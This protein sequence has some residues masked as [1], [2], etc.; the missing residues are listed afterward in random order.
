VHLSRLGV[1]IRLRTTVQR[2]SP[3]WVWLSTGEQLA[4]NTVVWCAGVAPSPLVSR[5]QLPAACLD[6]KGYI[7][8]DRDLRV[9][10]FENVWAIGD[11]A[12]NIDAHGRPYPATAQ[13]AIKEAKVLAANLARVI[14]GHPALPCDIKTRGSLAVI[15]E[16]RGIARI[17]SYRLSGLKAWF[18]NRA[19]YLWQI[20]GW[21]RKIRIGFDW[22]LD[23]MFS[24]DYVQLGVHSKLPSPGQTKRAA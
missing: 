3:E 15:G 12:V 14:D 10:S 13:H 16:H 1:D 22:M 24:R 23:L 6:N 11:C 17:G 19:Y 8:C 18:I 2:I 20:P 4:T 21:P 5:L 7:V 9:H